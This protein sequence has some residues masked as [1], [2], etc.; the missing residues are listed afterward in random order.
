MDP[1]DIPLAKN[2]DFRHC[3]ESTTV[4]YP[5]RKSHHPRLRSVNHFEYHGRK[6][7]CDPVPVKGKWGTVV[8][9]EI[10]GIRS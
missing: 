2:D 8:V 4:N 5:K 1:K 3:F 10:T 9:H 6:L 7:T